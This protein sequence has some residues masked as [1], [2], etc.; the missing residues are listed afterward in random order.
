MRAAP[1]RARPLQRFVTAPPGFDGSALS[2]RA[3]ALILGI[4]QVRN[5]VAAWPEGA[6]PL[7]WRAEATR[8]AAQ[9]NP[10]VVLAVRAAGGEAQRVSWALALLALE[11]EATTVT[12]LRA[13]AR[14]DGWHSW[15]ETDWAK[16]G[17]KVYKWVRDGPRGQAQ[18][19][20]G[21]DGALVAGPMAELRH[22]AAHWVPLWTQVED[23]VLVDDPFLAR[24]DGLPRM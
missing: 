3:A 22:A 21:P 24:L 15:V 7:P 13:K 11:A 8:R 1:A 6:G 18:F 9:R 20:A 19:V 12:A 14:R 23:A 4:R 2:K 10:A 16:G 5:L 17:R